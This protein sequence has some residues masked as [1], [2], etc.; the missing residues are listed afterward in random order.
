MVGR[1]TLQSFFS[2]YRR[3]RQKEKELQGSFGN[4]EGFSILGCLGRRSEVMFKS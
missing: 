1:L 4:N 2:H 3:W